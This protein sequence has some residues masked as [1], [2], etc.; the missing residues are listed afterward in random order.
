VRYFSVV[1]GIA[2][3]KILVTRGFATEIFLFAYRVATKI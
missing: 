2:T 3:K 1:S